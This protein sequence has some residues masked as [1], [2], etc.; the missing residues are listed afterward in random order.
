MSI[1]LYSKQSLNT[2]KKLHLYLTTT[3]TT[4]ITTTNLDIS[5]TP[6]INKM[7]LSII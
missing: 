2:F 7:S 6:Q 3:T 4:A 5:M 1:R